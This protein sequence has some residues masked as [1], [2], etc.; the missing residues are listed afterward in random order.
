MTSFI[1]RR[2]RAIA[3]LQIVI[4]LISL[5]LTVAGCGSS[6][7]H[8]A[9]TFT[10]TSTPR[11]G[12]LVTGE[13]GEEGL[14]VVTAS[15]PAAS[16]GN[17]GVFRVQVSDQG[18]Q[19]LLARDR[20]GA[21]HGLGLNIP[22]ARGKRG[23]PLVI[24]AE[25]TA[26]GLLFLTPGIIA[27]DPEEAI[28]RAAAVKSLTAFPPF[29]EYLKTT[30]PDTALED[31][32]K[33]DGQFATLERACIEEWFQAHPV[34]AGLPYTRATEGIA[35]YTL[36]SPATGYDGKMQFA[37][38]PAGLSPYADPVRSVEL[39]NNGW[40]FVEV[41]RR[42]TVRG[43][44]LTE[45][46]LV[47]KG[48]L[49]VLK[50]V[51]GFSM[52]SL[53][54]GQATSGSSLTDTMPR[55]GASKSE[56]YI[57]GPG[58]K[59][60]DITTPSDLPTK[61]YNAFGCT[62]AWTVVLPI[63]SLLGGLGDLFKK[64]DPAVL[65]ATSTRIWEAVGSSATLHDL[66]AAFKNDVLSGTQSGLISGLTN[67]GLTILGLVTASGALGSA[68]A[69]IGLAPATV[70][71]VAAG[72]ATVLAT[73]TVAFSTFN[74]LGALDGLAAYP[75]VTRF[76]V[77]D[78]HVGV[79]LDASPPEGE[80][81]LA[82]GADALTLTATVKRY[83]D[84]QDPQGTAAPAGASVRDA[85]V[86][87][88]ASA[89]TIAEGQT[90]QSCQVVTDDNGQAI[91]HLTS[92]SVGKATIEVRVQET[93]AE[94]I[95][96]PAFSTAVTR[97]EAQFGN[98]KATISP[99]SVT[100]LNRE[101]QGFTVKL[102]TSTPIFGKSRYIWSCGE[103]IDTTPGTLILPGIAPFVTPVTTDNPQVTFSADG[104]RTGQAT[105]TCVYEFQ[106]NNSTTW[107]P[108]A[109]AH[110]LVTVRPWDNGTLA[111]FITWDDTGR[112]S[113]TVGVVFDAVPGHNKYEIYGYNFNDPAYWGTKFDEV[114]D[115]S[116]YSH[117]LGA[118]TPEGKL[119]FSLTGGS[120]WDG[121]DGGMARFQGGIF[122][123]KSWYQRN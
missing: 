48:T 113:W 122:E 10:L 36:T 121:R 60:P 112:I 89:G 38:T 30:L 26:L 14:T 24:S 93:H 103:S 4:L 2:K 70:T 49:S 111:P 96:A 61:G 110:A 63:I 87:F 42:D 52:G 23:D 78:Y 101:S 8:P 17:G 59:A 56:Y 75:L 12:T 35:S 68:L 90:P 3:Y 73:T 54:T 98:A 84:A 116:E 47:S 92:T 77:E 65:A 46:N 51:N 37:E 114:G 85:Q 97:M 27:C 15:G 95:G 40:R 16:V 21:L 80:T 44:A 5:A 71:I 83:T 82:N 109:T 11:D 81:L 55:I 50:G 105:V 69:F 43:S 57:V 9:S 106:A 19:L 34:N 123:I 100:L 18:A 120:G 7:D 22:V 41:Y 31:L 104:Q 88:T 72:I 107:E 53:L 28:E 45:W 86:V 13:I 79:I 99:Q 108:I 20:E 58:T 67:I 74:F 117:V 29:V 32:V 76:T 33:G 39:T 62:V 118:P 25:T 119:F 6:G 1:S 91:I 102:S 94:K 64:L 66:I 115:I